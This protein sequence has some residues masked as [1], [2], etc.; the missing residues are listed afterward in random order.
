MQYLSESESGFKGYSHYYALKKRFNQN[1]L[2]R[3]YNDEYRHPEHIGYCMR[4]M[5]TLKPNGYEDAFNKY[6]ENGE[7]F[8]DENAPTYDTIFYR[9][10]TKEEFEEVAI[11]WK[12]DAGLTAMNIPLVDF[13][14]A[15][16]LHAIIETYDGYNRERMVRDMIKS[17]GGQIFSTTGKEDSKMGIDIKAKL[18]NRNGFVLIQIKP[19]TF[20]VNNDNVPLRHDRQTQWEKQQRALNAHPMSVFCYLVYY[21]TDEGETRWIVN[22]ETNKCSFDYDQLVDKE[23]TPLRTIKEMKQYSTPTLITK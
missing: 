5:E 8:R 23:G 10:R 1:D 3:F 18:P 17:L 13:Y 12:N 19:A 4:V 6:I 20:F 11:K 9:G 16:I 21:M 14:D 22:P 7:L 2:N 15:I